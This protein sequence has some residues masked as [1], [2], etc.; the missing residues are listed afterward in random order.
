MGFKIAVASDHA[1]FPLKEILKAYLFEK[2]LEIFDAGTYSQIAVDYPDF[3][4]KVAQGVSSGQFEKGL[5]V[6]GSGI[7]MSIVANKFPGVGLRFA[8]MKR[9]PG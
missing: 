2:G 9:W 7:G 4:I 3:G 1:G 5:L 8:L 6:C